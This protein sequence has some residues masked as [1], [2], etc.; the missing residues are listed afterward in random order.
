MYAK[1]GLSPLVYAVIYDI[2]LASVFL[3]FHQIW[4][5]F[6]LQY[7]YFCDDEGKI[8]R[9]KTKKTIFTG[10]MQ[11]A[12]KR[13]SG[14][15]KKSSVNTGRKRAVI[16]TM[17]AADQKVKLVGSMVEAWGSANSTRFF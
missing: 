2:L 8:F 5:F 11:A 16:A 12:K 4:S 9:E 10:E 14:T 13:K 3:Y 7:I 17:E 1:G 6:C 15:T